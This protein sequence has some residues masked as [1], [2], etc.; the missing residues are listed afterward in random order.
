[1]TDFRIYLSAPDV[2]DLERE[3]IVRALDSGWAAPAG[4]DLAAFEAE[5]AARVGVKAAVALSSGTAALHLAL[6]VLGV[7]AGDVVITSTLTFAATANAIRYVG[8]EPHFVD[9]DRT[10]GNIDV[11]LASAAAAQLRSE[12]RSIGALLPVDLF[13]KCANMHA[14]TALARHLDVPLVVDAAESMGATFDGRPAG[15]FGNASVLSF[16]GNKVMTTSGGGMFLTDDVDLADRVR[17]LSTQARQPVSHYEHTDVGY[18]YRLS[19]LLASL[20]RAQLA[21]LDQMIARR[22]EIREAY[23]SL[24]D[25]VA[26]VEILGGAD[27]QDNCWLTSIVA[28]TTEWAPDQLQHHLLQRGIESRRLWKPMH[29][30]PVYAASRSTLNGNSDWLFDHGLT[31]PS[32]SGMSDGDLQTVIDAIGEFLARQ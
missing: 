9:C 16:N 23:R 12:G 27:D 13:G 28:S 14:L 1:M 21:R 31:L 17:Y 11:E 22:R 7:S 18:N 6:L 20:G 26:G 24:F 25:S 10:T 29:L 5:V 19:N 30:Q 8:A 32:G 4:P 3:Y 15:S 2:G